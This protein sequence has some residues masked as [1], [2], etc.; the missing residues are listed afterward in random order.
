[1]KNRTKEKERK[2]D[3]KE[4]KKSTIKEKRCHKKS[5]N[6]IRTYDDE[7]RVPCS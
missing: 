3:K 2:K 7:F 4:R 1:M 6:L 5:A